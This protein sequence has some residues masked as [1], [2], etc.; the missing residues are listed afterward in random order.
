MRI[1]IYP[2]WSIT[3]LHLSRLIDLPLFTA[4]YEA[5]TCHFPSPWEPIWKQLYAFFFGFSSIK[6]WV[7]NRFYL[8]RVFEYSQDDFKLFGVLTLNLDRYLSVGCWEEVEGW[9]VKT[10]RADNLAFWLR[11]LVFLK[12]LCDHARMYF[13]E[14]FFHLLWNK[15]HIVYTATYRYCRAFIES[16]NYIFPKPWDVYSLTVC[17]TSCVLRY[18][19][20]HWV[21]SHGWCSKFVFE[22]SNESI[23][24][25]GHYWAQRDK[26]SADMFAR[27]IIHSHE[28]FLLTFLMS[29]PNNFLR[30]A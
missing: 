22:K 11:F 25:K 24:W 10:Q 21:W 7:I 26:E 3:S 9:D 2:S 16:G 1:S 30:S 13:C 6:C 29:S 15:I 8:V 18:T 23:A 5:R 17:Q 4:A 12:Y 14:M 19:V 28:H 27:L 20:H